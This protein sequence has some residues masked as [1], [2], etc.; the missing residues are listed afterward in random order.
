MSVSN[1]IIDRLKSFLDEFPM[2]KVRYGIDYLANVHTI[3]VYPSYLLDKDEVLIWEDEFVSDAIKLFPYD[4]ICVCPPDEVL[5]IGDPKFEGKGLDFNPISTFIPYVN[6]STVPCGLFT[7]FMFSQVF[8]SPKD[9]VETSLIEPS[10][11]YSL[12]A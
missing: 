9:S 6:E 3:E 4:L 1:F 8:Q 11:D 2:A 5:G 12:A 10:N 7:K